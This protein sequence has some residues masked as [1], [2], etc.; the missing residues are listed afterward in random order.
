MTE[1]RRIAT[2]QIN[3]Q[4]NTWDGHP[5]ALDVATWAQLEQD[6]TT[7][8][9]NAVARARSAGATW[10]NIADVFNVTRSAVQKR[11]GD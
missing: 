10:Q 9:R 3:Q 1:L 5:A 7:E 2:D 8:L 4:R 6:I 11:F